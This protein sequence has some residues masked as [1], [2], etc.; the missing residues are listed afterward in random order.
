MITANI[1]WNTMNTLDGMVGAK[2]TAVA[3]VWASPR[4]FR[5]PMIPPLSGPKASV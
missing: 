2:L 1:I 5:P 4:Y 3:P